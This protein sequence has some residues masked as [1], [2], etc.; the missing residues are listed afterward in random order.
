MR[1]W[2]FCPHFPLLTDVTFSAK[3]IPPAT[4]ANHLVAGRMTLTMPTEGQAGRQARTCRQRGRGVVPSASLEV[5]S[6]WFGAL[7]VCNT[8]VLKDSQQMASAAQRQNM[9]IIC[10]NP[11]I[12]FLYLQTDWEQCHLVQM[13]E[14]VSLNIIFLTMEGDP[15]YH[16]FFFF[17]FLPMG[18]SRNPHIVFLG[19]RWEWKGDA[20]L[21]LAAWQRWGYA[22]SGPV[23]VFFRLMLL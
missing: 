14:P 18:R 22:A 6:V 9:P 4:N 1:H 16:L 19:F 21:K 12:R 15:R 11:F 13:N 7:E 5:T 17:F 2:V 20:I 10:W 3:H 8:V 23:R